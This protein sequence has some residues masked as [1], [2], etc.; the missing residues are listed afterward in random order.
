[1]ALCSRPT[2]VLIKHRGGGGDTM[3]D[4]LGEPDVRESEHGSRHGGSGANVSIALIIFV[5]GILSGVPIAL[6]GVDLVVDNVFLIL[7]VM[8]AFLVTAALMTALIVAFRKP[9]LSRVVKRTE[10]EMERFARPLADVARYAAQQKVQEA[11]DAARE[12]GELMLA[13][14]AWVSTRRWMVATITA[15]VASIAAL[16]GSALLF[17]QNELLRAQGT[18]MREQTDRLTEQ[19]SPTLT[20]SVRRANASAERSPSVTRLTAELR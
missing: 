5:L 1:M 14:Y 3:T 18:L 12:V 16:A 10:V 13:R 4:D 11:T 15:F 17:Q 20:K 9:I 2:R 6:F 8:F 7:T 19:T